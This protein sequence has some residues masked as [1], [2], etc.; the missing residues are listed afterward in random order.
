V[1][2]VVDRALHS[3]LDFGLWAPKGSIFFSFQIVKMMRDHVRIAR[4][5]NG[6]RYREQMAEWYWAHDVLAA[7]KFI[8]NQ[9]KFAKRAKAMNGYVKP[10]LP[11]VAKAPKP[12]EK[13]VAESVVPPPPPPPQKGY[14]NWW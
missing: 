3:V 1:A 14:F 7:Q 8:N 4:A 9:D 11:K 13:E 12:V 5:R 6:S 10:E 2:D